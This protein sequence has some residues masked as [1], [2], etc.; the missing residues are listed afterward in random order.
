MSAD[1]T[2]P[3]DS[4]LRALA[5]EYG[6]K[7]IGVRPSL[8]RYIKQ[9]WDRRHFIVEYA[10]ARGQA[11]NTESRLGRLWEVLNPLFSVAIYYLVFGIILG[12]NKSV[13]NFLAFLVIGV[14]INSYTHSVVLSGS[15]S[16]TRNM[17]M[18]RSFHFPRAIMPL[19]DLVQ[20]F[21]LLRTSMLICCIIVVLTGQPITWAWL[22][23][24]PAILFQSMF[25]FGLAMVVARLTTRVRDVAK[26]LPFL[27]RTW[28]Y[29]SGVM[30]P[31]STFIEDKGDFV[32][33]AF[34]VNPMAV[35]IELAR[36]ALLESY[37][38]PAITWYLAVGWGIG[39]LLVGFIYFW[40]AEERY[41]RG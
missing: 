39:M 2:V 26:L 17:G 37:S 31:I 21:R 36:D 8:T 38:V 15:K 7:P 16:V 6:L 9:I 13:P 14:F 18:I 34:T 10:R 24:I 12:G 40:K 27:L 30:Y 22:L 28:T 25:N 35:Y 20:N 29:L 41:G 3:P 33:F 19:A 11:A 32:K 4:E 23:L 1:T 5:R